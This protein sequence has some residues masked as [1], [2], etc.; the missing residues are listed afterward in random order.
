MPVLALFLGQTWV[1]AVMGFTSLLYLAMFTLYQ[2]AL[3]HRL[4]KSLREVVRSSIESTVLDV[5]IWRPNLQG[6]LDEVLGR[7]KLWMTR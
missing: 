5:L 2:R 4:R 1:F 3:P 6:A 7:R